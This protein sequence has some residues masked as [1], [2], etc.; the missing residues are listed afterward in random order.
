[1]PHNLMTDRPGNQPGISLA[2]ALRFNGPQP[3][4]FGAKRAGAQAMGSGDFIDDVYWCGCC[5]ADQVTFYPH[6]NA[7]HTET[8][9]HII[10]DENQQFAPYQ[11]IQSTP[12]KAYILTVQPVQNYQGN[13]TNTPPISADDGVICQEM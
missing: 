10:K 1:M 9:G 13:E 12:I 4:H 11:L 2:I 8:I 5:N 6:C 7:T 3:N